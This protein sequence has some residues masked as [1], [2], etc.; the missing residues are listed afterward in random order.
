MNK[1][2]C[3]R[4]VVGSIDGKHLKINIVQSSACGGCKAHDLCHSAESK[5][6]HV[7]VY[8]SHPELYTIGQEVTLEGTHA[9]AR[10]AAMVA[11]G[12]PLLLLVLTLAI[13]LALTFSEAISSIAALAVVAFYYTFVACFMRG[14]LQRRLSFT[15]K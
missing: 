14:Y 2:L 1:T 13:M 3:H 4:G 11:Y 15:L 6:R 12:I 8:T 5:V 9:D 7:D 10:L